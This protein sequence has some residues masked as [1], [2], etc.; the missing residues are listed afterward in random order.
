MK[1]RK[2]LL[3]SIIGMIIALSIMYY[4]GLQ[5]AYDTTEK[6]LVISDG[7]ALV[8]FLYIGIGSLIWISMT[9][10]FD[11]F[12]YAIRRGAHALMPG[13]M[14]DT[15]GFYEYKVMKSEHRK[16]KAEKSTLIIGLAFLLI[17]LVLVAIWYRMV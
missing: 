6:L 2:Y 17:S 5:T 11:I 16:Q 4:R 13:R 14:Y 15:G 3:Q 1:F 7:F 9:G 8:S 10:I 12:G